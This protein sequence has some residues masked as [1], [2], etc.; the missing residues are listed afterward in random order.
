MTVEAYITLAVLA[1]VFA[2]LKGFRNS[3]MLTV[4]VL[5][6]TAAGMYSTGAITMIMDKIIGRSKHL[7]AVISNARKSIGSQ[8][9]WAREA[10]SL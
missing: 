3:G 1:V 2:L 10:L 5:F 6:I 8:E 4:G 7:G 9:W